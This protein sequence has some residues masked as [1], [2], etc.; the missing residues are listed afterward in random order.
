MENTEQMA[1]QSD[2]EP[3]EDSRAADRLAGRVDVGATRQAQSSLF[4]LRTSP[5]W[6]RKAEVFRAA[7]LVAPAS[8]VLLPG[9]AQVG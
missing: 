7:L 3:A 9:L 4:G 5:L 1:T 8:S 2:P 6:T